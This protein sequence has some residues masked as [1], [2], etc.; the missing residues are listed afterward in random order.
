MKWMI[1]STRR[2][3]NILQN[4]M[5]SSNTTTRKLLVAVPAKTY[6]KGVYRL[7]VISDSSDCFALLVFFSIQM[8]SEISKWF[9]KKD[10]KKQ[11]WILALLRLSFLQKHVVD[12]R[13]ELQNKNVSDALSRVLKDVNE[14]PIVRHDAPEVLGSI[15]AL[16]SAS[17]EGLKR[18]RASSNGCSGVGF[19]LPA[20]R[21]KRRI[22]RPQK[23]MNLKAT[24]SLSCSCLWA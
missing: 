6:Q 21:I 1:L 23:E 10:R 5:I 9:R 13:A 16:L 20:K 14:L 2:M 4:H 8:V 24:F 19:I 12:V 18:V 17:N 7:W 22:W 15:G 3:S 11:Y